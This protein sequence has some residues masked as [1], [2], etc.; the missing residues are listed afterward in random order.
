MTTFFRLLNFGA[1]AGLAVYLY[2]RYLLPSVLK[3]IHEK[4]LL[5]QNLENQKQGIKYQLNNLDQALE[6]QHHLEQE[7]NHKIDL[8][9][10]KVRS[11]NER[12]QLEYKANQ[13]KIDKQTEIKNK[14]LT[15]ELAN[16]RV[17][18]TILKTVEYTLTKE[19]EQ[20]QHA[21]KY[22]ND[23]LRFIEESSS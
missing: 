9:A 22:N 1:F 20:P 21:Q 14:K 23:I 15:F 4:K 3:Q 12:D 18:P 19:F 17:V 7:F 6:Q 2:K 8:W 13:E 11:K 10:A 16:K 5:L